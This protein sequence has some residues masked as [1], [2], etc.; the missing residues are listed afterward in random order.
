MEIAGFLPQDMRNSLDCLGL[1]Q[2]IKELGYLPHLEALRRI[3]DADVA[4]VIS[5]EGEGA[6]TAVP[7]KLY[8]YVA[9]DSVVLGLVDPGADPRAYRNFQMGIGVCFRRCGPDRARTPRSARPQR[10]GLAARTPRF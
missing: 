1:R 6:R 3:M 10:R 5:T 2:S 9:C 8:E 4:I 7:S